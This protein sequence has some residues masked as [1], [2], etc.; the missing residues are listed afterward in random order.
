MR[1]TAPPEP[2]S[3]FARTRLHGSQLRHHMAEQATARA[4]EVLTSGADRLDKLKVWIVVLLPVYLVSCQ[5]E[6][7]TFR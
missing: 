7:V 5:V 6:A 4:G 1:F 3:L 2:L